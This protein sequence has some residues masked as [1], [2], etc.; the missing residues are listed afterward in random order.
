MIIPLFGKFYPV[1]F[2]SQPKSLNVLNYSGVALSAIS[3]PGMAVVTEF[4]A[5]ALTCRQKRAGDD[6]RSPKYFLQRYRIAVGFHNAK[7]ADDDCH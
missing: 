2:F 6:Q 5:R 1:I 4:V 7:M 3:S